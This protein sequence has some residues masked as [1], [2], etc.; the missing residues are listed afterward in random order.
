MGYFQKGF[1][2]NNELLCINIWE[3]LHY[4]MITI[5]FKSYCK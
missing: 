5:G 2:H 4:Q 1:A 3:Y